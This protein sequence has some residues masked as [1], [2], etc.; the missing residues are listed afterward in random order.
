MQV[1]FQA[2]IGHVLK[3]QCSEIQVGTGIQYPYQVTM[4]SHSQHLAFS[5]KALYGLLDL[6]VEHFNRDHQTIVQ[7]AFENF[8]QTSSSQNFVLAEIFCGTNNLMVGH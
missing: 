5:I 7:L 8:A 1:C 4:P 2:T 6:H 3:Q